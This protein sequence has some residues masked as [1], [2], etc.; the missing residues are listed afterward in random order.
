[1]F[2]GDGKY[3]GDGGAVLEKVWRK[4]RWKELR[5]CPGRYTTSDS[6][7]R[8]KAPVRL[9][10]DLNVIL[11]ALVEL[12][13]EGKD[14]GVYVHTLN[15]ESGLIRKIDALQL[16]SYVPTLLAAEPVSANVA[17]FVGCLAV[18]PYLTDAEKNAS[19][20]ALNQ[21]L[22]DAAKRWQEGKRRSPNP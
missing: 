11:P 9:L 4:H 14:G 10:D 19:A 16:S 5:N 18:L 8:G 6:E 3:P 1:M 7:A 17:A 12:A 2:C 21:A 20:Y 22:R 13:P 15:T